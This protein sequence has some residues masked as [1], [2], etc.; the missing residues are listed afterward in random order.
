MRYS[1]LMF[2]AS[3]R[4]LSAFILEQ[5]QSFKNIR[6]LVDRLVN[7]WTSSILSGSLRGVESLYFN[8]K[9]RLFTRKVVV[10]AVGISW[11]VFVAVDNPDNVLFGHF[12]GGFSVLENLFPRCLGFWE[13][14]G[15]LARKR[16]QVKLGFLTLKGFWSLSVMG[17][18]VQHLLFAIYLLLKALYF[19]SHLSYLRLVLML[20]EWVYLAHKF[21]FFTH[22]IFMPCIVLNC[23]F[24]ALI[25]E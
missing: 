23:D 8:F 7:R 21:F 11:R 3:W 6:R 13:D 4:L 10:W 12:N 16:I 22:N 1:P 9:N 15:R 25:Q 14:Q 17:H 20:E 18:V 5:L 19:R 24:L 2:L